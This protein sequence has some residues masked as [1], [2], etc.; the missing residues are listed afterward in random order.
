MATT[1]DAP[2]A[3]PKNK[4]GRPKGSKNKRTLVSEALL[5]KSMARYTTPLNFLLGSMTNDKMPMAIRIDCAK[6][7]APYVHKRQPIAIE[8]SDKGPFRIFDAAKM[9]GMSEQE[10]LAL[11][12]LVEKATPTE[13]DAAE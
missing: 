13:D 9:G 6:A 5:A 7:A 12:T 4:G 10:L 1:K 2:S 8:N 3:R 11:K